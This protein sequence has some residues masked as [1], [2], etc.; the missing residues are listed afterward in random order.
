M[1]R[2]WWLWL[3]LASAC[4]I[5][6]FAI[7]EL[8]G[9]SIGGI[10]G[11]GTLSVLG[12]VGLIAGLAILAGLT[13]FIAGLLRLLLEIFISNREHLSLILGILGFCAIL[14]GWILT[15]IKLEWSIFIVTIG[16]FM[17]CLAGV[18]YQGHKLEREKLEYELEQ[19]PDKKEEMDEDNGSLLKEMSISELENF[20]DTYKDNKSIVKILDGYIKAKRKATKEF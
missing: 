17:G 7:S 16:F 4:L 20:K 18:E 8:T 15:S 2:K 6:V 11:W 19:V 5:I 12:I 10:F 9:I 13:F 14:V 3:L 1:K